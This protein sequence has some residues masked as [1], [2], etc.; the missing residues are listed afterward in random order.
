MPIFCPRQINAANGEANKVQNVFT[1]AWGG[2]PE[3]AAQYRDEQ[4]TG[5]VVIGDENYGEHF[6]LALFRLC[7]QR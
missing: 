3:I 2:V 7:L 4:K 5:W 1:G 6:M